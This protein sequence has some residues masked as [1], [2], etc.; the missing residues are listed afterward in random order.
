MIILNIILITIIFFLLW[1]LYNVTGRLKNSREFNYELTKELVKI[2]N[3][4]A[5]NPHKYKKNTTSGIGFCDICYSD[6]EDDGNHI[7]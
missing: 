4:L 2:H 3:L 1:K 5:N 7:K 6:N